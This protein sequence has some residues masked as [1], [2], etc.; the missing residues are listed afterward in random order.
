[1]YSSSSVRHTGKLSKMTS[2]DNGNIV[3]G[4]TNF[5]RRIQN[6]IKNLRRISLQKR[7][8]TK[9][10]EALVRRCSVKNVFLEISQNSHENTCARASFL[11]KS[12]AGV[13][14]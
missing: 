7:L 3:N 11:I 1:M 13:F 2:P 8:G 14:L 10:L 4:L 6:P 9:I 12:G 5:Q